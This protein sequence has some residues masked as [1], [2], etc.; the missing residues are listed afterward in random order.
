[1]I[2][3]N[4]LKADAHLNYTFRRSVTTLQRTQSTC[5][6]KSRRWIL[7]KK[8][9]TVYCE[10]DAKHINNFYDKML[11]CFSSGTYNYHRP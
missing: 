9:K 2:F 8:M 6:R 4:S 7:S 10:R 1:M 11:K 5:S 3:F